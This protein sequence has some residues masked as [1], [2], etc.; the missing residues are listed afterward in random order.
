M[1]WALH[2]PGY[3]DF[4][5]AGT[6]ASLLVGGHTHGGQ[7]RLPLLPAYRPSGSGRFLEGWYDTP[8]APF[9]VSRGVGTTTIRARFRCPAELPLFTLRR[10]KKGPRRSVSTGAFLSAISD[11]RLATDRRPRPEA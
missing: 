11:G 1:I 9:Y 2:A 3:A 8:S 5:P 4:I 7:I 6:P 10:T